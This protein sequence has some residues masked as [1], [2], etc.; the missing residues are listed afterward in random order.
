MNS[1]HEKAPSDI[2]GA[3]ELLRAA[4]A[5]E[6]PRPPW[7][8]PAEPVE[9]MSLLRFALQRA[10][11]AIGHA[12]TEELTAALSLVEAARSDVDT[13]ETALLLTARAEGLTWAQIATS[14]GLRSPQAAQQRYQRISQRPGSETPAGDSSESS[15]TSNA[16]TA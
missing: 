14:L 2:D 12:S 15:S 10:N 9:A 3:R 16:G 1:T 7:Q 5:H 8:H 4:A 13:L 11:A 6:L